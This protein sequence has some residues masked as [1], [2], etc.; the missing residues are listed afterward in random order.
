MMFINDS[1]PILIRGLLLLHVLGG[2]VALFVFLIPL[3]TKKG[4]RT[5]IRAGKVYG[6]GMAFVGFTAFP[7]A[8]WRL[9]LD[10][11]R[12]S[13]SQSFAAFLFFVAIL[14]LASVWFGLRTLKEKQ[15]TGPDFKIIN[16]GLSGFLLAAALLTIGVGFHFGNPLVTYFPLVGVLTAAKQLKYWLTKPASKMHWWYAHMSGMIVASIATVTAFLVTALPRLITSEALASSLLLWLSPTII[17]VPVLE[18][19]TRRYQRQFGD[20]K[21]L[22]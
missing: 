10:P 20:A 13:Q 6:I 5:H 17:L 1:I 16:I 2:A 8:V 22:E 21:A 18:I 19:W 15:R 3:L 14:S 9:I 12:S 4:G 11:S 7:I